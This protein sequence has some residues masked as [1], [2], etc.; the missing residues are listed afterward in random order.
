MQVWMR[1]NGQ[2]GNEVE[3]AGLLRKWARS[4]AC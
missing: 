4:A 2:L 1:L 3:N